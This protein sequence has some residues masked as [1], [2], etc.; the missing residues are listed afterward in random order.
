MSSMSGQHSTLIEAYRRLRGAG[1]SQASAAVGFAQAAS[2]QGQAHLGVAIL[3]PLAKPTV[4]DAALWQCL[5]LAYRDEQDM[6]SAL[7]ALRRAHKLDP[8]NAT[9]AFAYAQVLFETARDATAA[10]A[11]ARALSPNNPSL[12]RTSAAALAAQGHSDAAQALLVEVLA[13]EPQWLDG[14]KTLA[15]L[16]VAGGQRDSF[17]AS[18]K[19][20]VAACPQS[21][22]LRLAWLHLL[23][24]ARDWDSAR[25]VLQQA[26]RDFGPQQGLELVRVHIVSE[27]GELGCDDP[28]LFDGVKDVSDAG[29]DLCK[30]RQALRAGDPARAAA[31]AGAYANHPAATLFWPYVAL[32][33]HLL[34][35]ARA[36]WL[37]GAPQPIAQYDLK[38]TPR[39][40]A[41]LVAALTALHI[42]RAPFL[43]QSV[44]GGTQTTGQL[45]FRPLP[46]IQAIRAKIETAVR[47]YIGALGGAVE[48]HPLLAPPRDGPIQFEGSWSVALK[49][50]GHHSTHTHPKGW[51]S[52]AFYVDVPTPDEIGTPP[53]GWISFGEGPPELKLDL[54]PYQQIAP[55]AGKLVLF[56]STLWHRTVPFDQGERLTIA[57]D[58]KVP[59]PRI[60]L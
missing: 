19:A 8:T 41:D 3:E 46:A 18:L 38:L 4:K 44:H 6:E 42:T 33:W 32:A 60:R 31:I 51:I 57:F 17:D 11:T 1:A 43:E 14:H 47:D 29:L 52:S 22:S 12:I 2:A 15:A 16:R 53:A 49:A 28:A 20:A 45:F 55:K 13:R 37:D 56:P 30:V 48:G 21:L 7:R 26:T 40:R 24:T 9:T 39:E 10:F 5:G 54:R 58:V 59:G 36:H 50:G 25:A 35:D 34:G 27:A 23:S